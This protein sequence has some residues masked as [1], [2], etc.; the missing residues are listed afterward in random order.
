MSKITL[1]KDIQAAI[2]YIEDHLKEPGLTTSTIAKVSGYSYWH[3][4][5]LFRR[6]TGYS[7]MGYCRARRIFEAAQQLTQT[8]QSITDIAIEWQFDSSQSFARSFTKLLTISP[9]AWRKWD[10]LNGT[11]RYLLTSE[12]IQ[13]NKLLS[14]FSLYSKKP[15]TLV[16]EICET[17]EQFFYGV[18]VNVSPEFWHQPKMWTQ[19][20]K[21]TFDKLYQEVVTLQ[22]PPFHGFSILPLTSGKALPDTSLFYG[23]NEADIQQKPPHWQCLHVPK[24]QYLKFDYMGTYEELM[25]FY[26]YIFAI[27]LPQTQF[28]FV[29]APMILDMEPK[30]LTQ[31]ERDRVFIYVPVKSIS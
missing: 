12:N 31:L 18:E 3:L 28:R 6:K 5:E 9:R 21:E 15:V 4:Q 2:D 10:R 22:S 1:S 8:D 24:R 26:R 7:V 17:D 27:Y 25:Q 14:I 23:F 29:W 16:P 13:Q 30:E 20:G 19:V 11:Y